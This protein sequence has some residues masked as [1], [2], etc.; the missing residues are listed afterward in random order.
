M[1]GMSTGA[2]LDSITVASIMFDRKTHWQNV[3]Q[4]KS[5]LDVS[6]Y[7]KEPSLSLGLIRK[8]G[9]R[10]DDAIIDVG[11][12]ASLLVDYLCEAGYTNLS[13][14]DISGNALASSKK[15]LGGLAERIAWFEA[16]ITE[17]SPP[18]SFAL[19]HDRAVFHFLTEKTDRAKYV[20]ALKQ[21]LEPGGH[22]VVAA[23]AI[24]G[25]EKCSGL[26]IEQYDAPKLLHELGEGFRLLEEQAELHMTPA[27]KEQ[28]FMYFHLVRT[29]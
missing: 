9:V 15:R 8:S 5:P 28:A 12:G 7:Q 18:H 11:G 23:F 19:W 27:N 17:F 4:E 22:L 26:T 13:V 6:W 1:E 21:G 24:G 16:D 29:A 3:Y 14:L 2:E 10:H 25:P 20:T